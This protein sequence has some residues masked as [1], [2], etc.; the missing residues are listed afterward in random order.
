MLKEKLKL[1]L[2]FGINVNIE[3]A[4]YATIANFSHNSKESFFD[5]AH[6]PLISTQRTNK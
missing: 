2:S 3:V 6:F 1:V 4:I 5:R